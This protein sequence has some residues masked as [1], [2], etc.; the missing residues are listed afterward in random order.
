MLEKLVIRR[1]VYLPRSRNTSLLPQNFF[2]HVLKWCK[3]VVGKELDVRFKCHHKRIVARHFKDSVS[4]VKQM[5]GR[6]HYDIQHTIVAMIAGR[7]PPRFLHAVRALIDFIY[8]AQSPVHTDSSIDQME[9]SLR[10]FHAHKDV[11]IK[12]G[13]RR[14][15]AAGSK[16]DFYIPKLELLLSFTRAIRKNGGLIQ[17]SA[18]VSE[19]LLITHCKH[20]FE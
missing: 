14:T 12:V 20:P 8:Q 11:I 13:A 3:E 4:H 19:H 17:Y 1:A 5:T 10:E 7:V 6:E 16:D 18:D 9:S 2:D 15:K